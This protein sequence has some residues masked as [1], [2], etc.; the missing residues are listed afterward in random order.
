MTD[1]TRF[2]T[3]ER[4]VPVPATRQP[5]FAT[6]TLAIE[7]VIQAKPTNT[8]NILIF[9]RL[10]GGVQGAELTPGDSLPVNAQWVM[11]LPDLSAIFIDTATP[12]DGVTITWRT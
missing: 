4:D 3:D 12:D 7:A 1:T 6:E 8:T 11:D 2:H 5:L 9:D 10:V